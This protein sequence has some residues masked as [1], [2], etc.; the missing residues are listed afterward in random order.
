MTFLCLLYPPFTHNLFLFFLFIYFGMLAVDYIARMLVFLLHTSG[1]LLD[2][3]WGLPRIRNLL[4]RSFKKYFKIGKRA[5]F[6]LMGDL[7]L[8][9]PFWVVSRFSISCC[10][11]LRKKLSILWRVLEGNSFGE[12]K[13]IIRKIIGLLGAV[14][15]DLKKSRSQYWVS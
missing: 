6:Y 9:S 7:T 12:V 5:P 14:W 10:S 4:L 1:F 8:L 3:T 15:L 13:T 2:P 11:K